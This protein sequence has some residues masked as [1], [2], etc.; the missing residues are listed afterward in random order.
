MKQICTGEATS[1]RV[2]IFASWTVYRPVVDNA[3]PN[4][5]SSHLFFTTVHIGCKVFTV[6]RALNFSFTKCGINKAKYKAVFTDHHTYIITEYS[7]Y[8][9]LLCP[10]FLLLHYDVSLCKWFLKFHNAEN[11]AP[12]THHHIPVKLNPKFYFLKIFS[13]LI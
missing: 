1:R 9:L 6:I 10:R 13:Q 3:R 7:Y 4:F 5:Q 2:W 8:L 11:S 12:T